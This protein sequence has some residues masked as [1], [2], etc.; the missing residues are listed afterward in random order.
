MS[1]FNPARII[2]VVISLL[3][4]SCEI[5]SENGISYR[6]EEEASYVLIRDDLYEDDKGNLYFRT[7]DKSSISD[8][9]EFPEKWYVYNFAEYLYVDS[10]IGENSIVTT[11]AINEVVD[12]E[13]F[14]KTTGEQQPENPDGSSPLQL[15][16][17][18]DKNNGYFLIHVADG[19]VLHK[20]NEKNKNNKN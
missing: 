19:G 17:Y 4:L 10:L 1:T 16:Y 5:G 3:F 15:S 9:P 14:H 6:L 20:R 13:T 8:D 18:A 7:I 11:K 2:L 12:A